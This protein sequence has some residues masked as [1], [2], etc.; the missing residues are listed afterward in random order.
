LSPAVIVAERIFLFNGL[1]TEDPGN[2]GSVIMENIAPFTG[3]C[4]SEIRLTGDTTVLGNGHQLL[5]IVN[6]KSCN[7]DFLAGKSCWRA[8]MLTTLPALQIK[9]SV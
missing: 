6:G 7:G 3:K 8:G 2:K 4:A 5:V 1:P 9:I